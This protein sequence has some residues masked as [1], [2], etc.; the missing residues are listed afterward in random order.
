MHRFFYTI[1]QTKCHWRALKTYRHNSQ[2]HAR[3]TTDIPLTTLQEK[4]IE[5]VVLDFD[6]VLANHGAQSPLPEVLTWLDQANLLFPNNLY[7]LSNKPNDS[8]K[9]YF[10][11][12]YPDIHFIAGVRKKPYPDGLQKIIQMSKTRPDKIVL[13]DD[14]L[15]TGVLATLIT[16]CKAVWVT[17][18]YRQFKGNF[19][20]EVFFSILR[21]SEKNLI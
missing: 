7:L 9:R 4:G 17:K 21:I 10:A 20:N 6:G 2:W 11:E 1:K 8:R 3:H 16:G 12:H 15:L 5:T 13:I 19:C 18:A 14:R